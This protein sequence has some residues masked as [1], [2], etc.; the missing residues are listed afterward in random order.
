VSETATKPLDGQLGGLERE[1][2][3]GD[4]STYRRL[5]R[6]D[7]VV[8]VPGRALD[9]AEA[10]QEIDE[11]GGWDGF[12]LADLREERLGADAALVTYRFTGHRGVFEYDAL[13]SS[14]YTCGADG[15]WLLLHHQQTPLG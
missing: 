5:L 6:E 12:D 2:A 1:L 7:A 9:K 14:V 8:I 11:A 4:G 15:D 3:G 10:I 13:L